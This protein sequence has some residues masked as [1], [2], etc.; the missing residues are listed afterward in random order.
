MMADGSKR[1][2]TGAGMMNVSQSQDHGIHINDQQ[3]H[4]TEIKTGHRQ[5]PTS[6]DIR[7]MT[8]SQRMALG[9]GSRAMMYTDSKTNYAS[10]SRAY[11]TREDVPQSRSIEKPKGSIGYHNEYSTQEKPNMAGG[12]RL[13]SSRR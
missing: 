11:Q 4:L 7:D 3:S 1:F 10:P 12:N 5:M 13:S 2:M 9:I 8:K 6:K